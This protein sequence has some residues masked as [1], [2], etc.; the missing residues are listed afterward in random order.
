MG[1]MPDFAQSGTAAALLARLPLFAHTSRA[2]LAEL[3]REALGVEARAGAALATRGER[4]PGLMVVRYGLVKLS[5]RGDGEKV[6]RL[7]GPGESF[8]EAALFLEQPL[9]IDVTALSDSALVVVPAAPLLELFDHDRRFARSLL[10][11][12]C[13]RLHGL[14]VD[15]EAVTVH[16]ARERLASYIDSL[17]PADGAPALVHLPA[18]KTVVASRL[19]MTKETLSRLLRAFIDEG[20]IVVAR[21]DI[22]LLDRARLRAVALPASAAS[23]G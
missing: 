18:S 23:R 7:V 1:S 16:G 11:S 13:Q 22:E 15:F 6:L 2:Q 10:A 21:R 3:A 12:V 8:G 17:A 14:V 20:L 9:P 5:L 19:G 4:L